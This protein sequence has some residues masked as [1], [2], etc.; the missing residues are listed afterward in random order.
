MGQCRVKEV[1]YFEPDELVKIYNP[2]HQ[3]SEPAVLNS[4]NVVILLLEV[5]RSIHL[6]HQRRKKFIPHFRFTHR[7]FIGI[8]ELLCQ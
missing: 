7:Q 8:H 4:P 6:V 2:V 1:D 5:S 3:Y